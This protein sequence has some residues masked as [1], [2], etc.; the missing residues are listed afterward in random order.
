MN[1]T[2]SQTSNNNFLIMNN[3]EIEKLEDQLQNKQEELCRA[4]ARLELKQKEYDKVRAY[5]DEKVRKMSDL[6]EFSKYDGKYWKVIVEKERQE[7]YVLI[8][9]FVPWNIPSYSNAIMRN[10]I[11]CKKAFWV[12]T[13]WESG[14]FKT[15]YLFRTDCL[16]DWRE[17]AG[18]TANTFRIDYA[19]PSSEEE[20]NAVMKK[21][22]QL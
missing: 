17:T 2:N 10:E 13:V 1:I 5:I 22:L 9:K 12:R 3:T 11:V 7:L 6:E 15:E 14:K 4:K 16:V 21:Y 18:G 8:D 20:F 19:K